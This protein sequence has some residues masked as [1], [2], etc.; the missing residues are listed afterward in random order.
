VI[1]KMTGYV[2]ALAPFAICT[3]LAATVLT[4]GIGMLIV[5]AKFI[6]SFYLSLLL[7]WALLSCAVFLSVG[8]RVGRL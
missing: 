4:Q 8:R 6:G 1:L 2:M 3:A 5:Y 7:L